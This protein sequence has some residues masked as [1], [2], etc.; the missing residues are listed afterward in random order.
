[1]LACSKWPEVKQLIGIMLILFCLFNKY[2]DEICST[3]TTRLNCLWLKC[4]LQINNQIIGWTLLTGNTQKTR[5]KLSK[6]HKSIESDEISC[7]SVG[8]TSCNLV[9]PD[10]DATG[11]LAWLAWRYVSSRPLRRSALLHADRWAAM[12]SSKQTAGRCTVQLCAAGVFGEVLTHFFHRCKSLWL[13]ARQPLLERPIVV[14]LQP[15]GD[16]GS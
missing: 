5:K 1:M 9:R 13:S 6:L 15:P 14:M 10:G 4:L 12:T 8:A 3:R 11:G 16:Y 7:V 2:S